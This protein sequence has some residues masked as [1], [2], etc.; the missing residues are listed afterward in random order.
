MTVLELINDTKIDT[1]K[2]CLFPYKVLPLNESQGHALKEVEK[3]TLT[4]VIGAAGTGKTSLIT[5]VTA[6]YVLTGRNVLIV[7]KSD[8]AV[9]VVANKLN[10]L[11][12]GIIALRGGK[13]ECMTKL[14]SYLCDLLDNK[15]DLSDDE[16]GNVLKYLINSDNAECM[17]MLKHSRNVTLSELIESI[18]S[19]QNLLTFAKA[20]M[21]VKKSTRNSIMADVDFA[22]ILKAVPVWCVTSAEVS[23]LLPLIKDMFSLLIV[24]ESSEMDIASFIPCAYRAQ[25]A[26]VVGDNKQ[27]KSLM[28]MDNKKNTSFFTKHEISVAKQ[29]IWNYAK[30]SLFDFCQYYTEKCI[31][32]KEQY[33]MPEN[34]F[35]FANDN[36]Y[37]GQIKSAKKSD[38]NALKKIF[39]NGGKT[40][41]NKTCNFRE[42]EEII[43]YLK[44]WL[45][46]NK[47][48]NK[49]IA[50]LSM[51]KAQVDLILKTI[52]EVIPYEDIEKHQITVRSANSAQGSEWDVCLI[53]H[54]VAANSKH[55]SKSFSC[56]PHRLN[57]LITRGR[58]KVINFYS[59]KNMGNNLLGQYLSKIGG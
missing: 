58:E 30:N 2:S 5:A 45:K 6:H 9:D 53:S 4:T 55:Q 19:R 41:K 11:G 57:V 50:I 40:E 16:K 17:K 35:K 22:P 43:R 25:K 39:V 52:E 33:R 26:L 12:A 49:T 36:F 14:I 44:N 46:E 13:G 7:S 8:H 54:C 15:I 31:M 10:G 47:D 42:C 1:K 24:D 38:V 34:V 28:F 21:A 27:L 20:C 29:Q 3:N 56:E 37:G 18:K 59:T 51:F 48:N 23:N 32:L